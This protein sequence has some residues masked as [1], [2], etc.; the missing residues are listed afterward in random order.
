MTEQQPEEERIVVIGPGGMAVS[1][2]PSDEEDG[3]THVAD[4]VEQPA[5]VMRIGSMIRQ[6]LDEVKSAPLDEAARTRLARIFSSSIKELEEGL[7]PELVA[8]LD[9]LSLP[10][11]SDSP[12]EAELRIAQAQLVG[13]ARRPLPRDPDRHLRPADGG[14]RAAGADAAGASPGSSAGP[15]GRRR[16]YARVTTPAAST[17]SGP[18]SQAEQGL[19]HPRHPV[20]VVGRRHAAAPQPGPTGGRWPSRTTFPPTP[21]CR[22]RWAC[23]RTPPPRRGQDPALGRRSPA[24][25]IP[26]S[27]RARSS[28]PAVAPTRT[29]SW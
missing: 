26:W 6:L 22:R 14:A 3:D 16:P 11:A 28:P 27:P 7:A 20:V 1:P 9:R 8:E 24:G 25:P 23:P 19:Q 5:K 21:A 4:L 15:A 29:T 12:S 13:L 17:C 18:G 10:F 2:T